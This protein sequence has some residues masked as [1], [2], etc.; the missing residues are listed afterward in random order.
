MSDSSCGVIGQDPVYQSLQSV[1]DWFREAV[2]I[3]M[4]R[5]YNSVL[6][7]GEY[8]VVM[9]GHSF[10]SVCETLLSSLNGVSL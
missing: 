7:G 8:G 5:K 1:V 10:H 4:E 9:T 3:P 6:F 2:G